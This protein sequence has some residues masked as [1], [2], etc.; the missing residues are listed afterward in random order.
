MLVNQTLPLVPNTHRKARK[1]S[2]QH[3]NG[4]MKILIRAVTLVVQWAIIKIIIKLKLEDAFCQL[5]NTKELSENLSI[6][7]PYS[8]SICCPVCCCNKIIKFFHSYSNYSNNSHNVLSV[9]NHFS[10]VSPNLCHIQNSL[11]T[12]T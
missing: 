3:S 12:L 7:S 8:V 9:V 5:W 4:L 6:P 11:V 2:T 10:I 1:T